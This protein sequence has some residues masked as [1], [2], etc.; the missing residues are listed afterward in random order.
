MSDSVGVCGFLFL[1]CNRKDGRNIVSHQDLLS[2]LP[3][4]VN[5]VGCHSLG[6]ECQ[7]ASPPTIA[8]IGVEAHDDSDSEQGKCSGF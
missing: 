4:M 1:P 8:K 5:G 2:F 6:R 3:M 7:L